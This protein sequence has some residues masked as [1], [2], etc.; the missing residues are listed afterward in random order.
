MSGARMMAARLAGLALRRGIVPSMRA[1]STTRPEFQINTVSDLK[2]NFEEL[3][4]LKEAAA[5][6]R[7]E[8]VER[9][10]HEIP[11]EPSDQWPH[12]H[13]ADVAKEPIVPPPPPFGPG[14]MPD[15]S[16]DMWVEPSVAEIMAPP[17]K[18]K[19]DGPI[20]DETPDQEPHL[21]RSDMGEMGSKAT[22]AGKVQG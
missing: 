10:R 1:I 14:V 9:A 7:E 18:A 19:M 21:S 8:T 4:R 22:G 17:K 11:E 16:P 13:K 20:P 2:T 12:L 5:A 6:S 15:Q 3:I